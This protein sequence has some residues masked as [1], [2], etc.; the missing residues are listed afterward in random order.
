MTNLLQV[1]QNLTSDKNAYDT[2]TKILDDK[3]FNDPLYYGADFQ[4]VEDKGTSHT[5]VLAPNGD[6]VS[7]TSSI[8]T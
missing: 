3:T 1:I 8:N 6:A 4:M 5:S 7:V 2:F